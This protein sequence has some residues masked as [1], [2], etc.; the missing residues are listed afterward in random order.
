MPD[1]TRLH[2]GHG[3]TVLLVSDGV[4]DAGS[5]K[6]LIKELSRWDDGPPREL[7]ERVMKAG[8]RETGRGDDMTV[9]AVRVEPSARQRMKVVSGQ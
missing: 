6:W 3:E 7:A 5:D 9:M 8:M 2:L 4:V 1:V